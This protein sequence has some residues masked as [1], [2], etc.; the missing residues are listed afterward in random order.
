MEEWSVGT[1][2]ERRAVVASLCEPSLLVDRDHASRVLDILQAITGSILGE[3]DRRSEGFRVLRK[4]LAYGWSVVVA[5]Q[6]SIGKPRMEGW[7]RSQ[8][9][10]IRWI[11]KQNLKKKRLTRMDE[12]WVQAQLEAM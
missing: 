2:L 6:P 8:D 5:A 10:D 12:S 4:G 9:L 3:E 11:M 7:I 1:L